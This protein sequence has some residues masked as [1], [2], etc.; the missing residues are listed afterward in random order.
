MD[1]PTRQSYI[2]AVVAPHE[3]TRAAG[4]TQLVRMAGWA[5]APVF[6][7]MLMQGTSLALPLI[8][9]ASMKVAYDVLLYVAFRNLKPPEER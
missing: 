2:V 5:V 7:G 8:I 3:R 1:V 9:G 6:A 4:I